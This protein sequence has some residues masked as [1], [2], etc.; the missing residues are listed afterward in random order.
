[1]WGLANSEGEEEEGVRDEV[2]ETLETLE[3]NSTAAPTHAEARPHHHFLKL[4]QRSY[5]IQ[6]NKVAQKDEQDNSPTEI[7]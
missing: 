2:D 3:E 7:Q 4:L 1:D 6:A 5:C